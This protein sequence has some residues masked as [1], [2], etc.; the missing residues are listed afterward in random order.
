[1]NKLVFLFLLFTVAP[2]QAAAQDKTRKNTRGKVTATTNDLEGIY[3][4]NKQTKEEIQT[5]S[6]GYFSIPAAVGDTLMVSSVQFKAD[7]RIVTKEDLCEEL[8]FIKLQL[9]ANQIQEVK[10][11]QYK[12][13]NA[14]ALGIIPANQKKYTPAERKLKTASALDAQIGLNTSLMIDPLLNLL[15]GRTAMLRKELIVERK[16]TLLQKI[17]NH[18][19]KEFFINR[20]KIPEEYVKGFQYYTIENTR[21]AATLNAKNYTLATFILGELA[22]KYIEII[23]SENK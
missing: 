16:E 8:L 17:N 22:H 5:E 1:M 18:F 20:L 15:S 3:I 11:F 12:N 19:D 7:K 6:G 4:I 14:V 23:T 9:L 10:I 2:N 13:I 21:F